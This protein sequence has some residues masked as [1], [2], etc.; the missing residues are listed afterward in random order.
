MRKM[1]HWLIYKEQDG[2][3]E[4]MFSISV[5]S[6]KENDHIRFPPHCI[7][8]RTGKVE[9]VNYMGKFKKYNIKELLKQFEI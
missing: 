9:A 8:L 7:D 3:S 4:V 6:E 2:C 1:Q 5:Y